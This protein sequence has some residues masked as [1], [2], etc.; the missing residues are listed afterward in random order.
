MSSDENVHRERREHSRYDLEDIG[1]LTLV[2]G[3]EG[4]LCRLGDVSAAGARL[5]VNRRPDT[6]SRLYLQSPEAGA[7]PLEVV[8]HTSDG[9]GV[10]FS[11][12]WATA[13]FWYGR[14]KRKLRDPKQYQR[15][16]GK[17]DPA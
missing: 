12:P 13:A 1:V 11:D 4:A 6:G 5:V 16:P 15:A 17:R 3:K 7:L 8:R 2:D 14:L 9:V 10:R